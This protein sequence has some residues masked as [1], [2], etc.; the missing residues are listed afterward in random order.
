MTL[1]SFKQEK[2]VILK[3]SIKGHSKFKESG[4][5]IV[6]SSISSIITTTI[7]GIIRINKNAISYT[8]EFG[9]VTI[10]NINKDEITNKL[11]TNMISLLKELESNYPK[12]IKLK[13][14]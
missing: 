7:N 5:D 3:I 4:K 6:C 12:N 9:Y 11:L 14:E 10:E 13:E 2:D 8:D 1:V